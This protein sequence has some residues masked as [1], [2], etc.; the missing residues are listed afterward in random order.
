MLTIVCY[1]VPC[2]E[3]LA[4]HPCLT[5]RVFSLLEIDRPFFMEC[6]FQCI[7]PP[8]AAVPPPSKEA[9]RLYYTVD[10]APEQGLANI[11]KHTT[12]DYCCVP[13]WKPRRDARLEKKQ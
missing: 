9:A 7:C 2:R 11:S 13:D 10:E 3:V 5:F 12:V 4:E 8:V 1:H 6:V